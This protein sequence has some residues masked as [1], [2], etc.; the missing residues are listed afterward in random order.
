MLEV[1][2]PRAHDTKNT[3]ASRIQGRLAFSMSGLPWVLEVTG[4]RDSRGQW[5][6][7]FSQ[8]GPQGRLIRA[9]RVE[10]GRAQGRRGQGLQGSSQLRAPGILEVGG[11]ARGCGS[12]GSG[13]RS[14]GPQRSLT[15]GLLKCSKPVPEVPQVFNVGRPGRLVANWRPQCA[16]LGSR[17]SSNCICIC[18]V[19][20]RLPA[21]LCQH[22]L[23]TC[24]CRSGCSLLRATWVFYVQLRAFLFGPLLGPSV[25]K[26]LRPIWGPSN[27]SV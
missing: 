6:L 19:Y 4:S 5:L 11:F 2:G 15:S 25:F 22:L 12:G 7:R 13:P 17:Q 20:S 18:R 9:T 10:I 24:S 27:C 26:R 21:L 3:Q 14:Q 16:T 8:S 23:Q 1:A